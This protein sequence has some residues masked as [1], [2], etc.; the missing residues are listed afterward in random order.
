M[1]FL[2]FLLPSLGSFLHE[3]KREKWKKEQCEEMRRGWEGAGWKTSYNEEEIR[4]REIY[5]LWRH[6]RRSAGEF[7][8]MGLT[9]RTWGRH[10]LSRRDVGSQP[11][12][13]GN[14]RIDG[15][16]VTSF[17][18]HRS[19][20]LQNTEGTG[21]R[22]RYPFPTACDALTPFAAESCSG[23]VSPAAAFLCSWC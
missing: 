15:S 7:H 5:R 22:L 14:L 4:K 16:M 3:E 20:I 6:P 1:L 18:W 8:D 13:S 17:D 12:R 10:R 19:V 11:A 2:Y 9:N 21:E 23:G